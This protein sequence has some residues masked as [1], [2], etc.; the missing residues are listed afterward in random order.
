MNGHLQSI[1]SVKK[2]I[3]Y[4][5][6]YKTSCSSCFISALFVLIVVMLP[7]MFSANS[8]RSFPEIIPQHLPSYINDIIFISR[9]SM[10]LRIYL[11]S[12][13]PQTK[14]FFIRIGYRVDAAS[15]NCHSFLNKDAHS[16]MSPVPKQLVLYKYCHKAISHARRMFVGF[17]SQFA[18]PVVL[19]IQ[20]PADY[21]PML[22]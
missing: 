7:G 14:G 18:Q 4:S 13:I 17:S 8:S 11:T 3:V 9:M 22:Y 2:K 6:K 10:L 5:I 1:F 19:S 21:N 16:S 20:S 15:S 12:P